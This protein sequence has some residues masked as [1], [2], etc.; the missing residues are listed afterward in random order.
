MVYCLHVGTDFYIGV[1]AKT[2]S[3]LKLSAEVRFNK[4]VYRSRSETKKWTLCEA[5]RKY[6][7]EAFV[8]TIAAVVRGKEAAHKLER[9]MLRELQPTLNTDMRGC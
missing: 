4:H 9:E 5:I 1:T 6:G 3:T 2:M 8:V 7:S